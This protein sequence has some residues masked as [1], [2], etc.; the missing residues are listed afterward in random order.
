MSIPNCLKTK[1][2]IKEALTTFNETP[3]SSNAMDPWK[4]FLKK[5]MLHAKPSVWQK[6][7]IDTKNRGFR[8][9]KPGE[10]SFF[11]HINTL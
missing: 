1:E 5:K 10:S 9:Q 3:T 11:R 4:K 7:Y 6:W 8:G 2:A